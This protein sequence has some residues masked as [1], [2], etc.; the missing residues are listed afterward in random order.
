MLPGIRGLSSC[1]PVA[2]QV[3]PHLIHK[4]DHVIQRRIVAQF[5]IIAARNVELAANRREGLGLLDRIYTQIGFQ[6]EIEIEHVR[7]I[8]RLLGDDGKNAILH[9]IARWLSVTS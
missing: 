2:F 3:R 9:D 8:A 7:R 5:Q 6:I 4:P 1:Q